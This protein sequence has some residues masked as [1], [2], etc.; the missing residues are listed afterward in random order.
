MARFFVFQFK[1]HKVGVGLDIVIYK[2]RPGNFIVG[3]N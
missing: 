3:Y 2:K 1:F